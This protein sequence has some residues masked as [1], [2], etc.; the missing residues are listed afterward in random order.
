[1]DTKQLQPL[2][3]VLNKRRLP[4][5]LPI[6]CVYT[7]RPV[8]SGKKI[9]DSAREREKKKTKP[10]NER[11]PSRCRIGAAGPASTR[12]QSYNEKMKAAMLHQCS[13]VINVSGCFYV[14][15]IDTELNH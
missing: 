6:L 10:N 3:S 14:G 2:Y 8:L 15:H 7:Y 1:M 12:Q 11:L 5:L 4:E 13:C 9:S